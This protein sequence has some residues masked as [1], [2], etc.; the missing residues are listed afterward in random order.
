MM[1]KIN[2]HNGLNENIQSKAD[3]FVSTFISAQLGYSF[4]KA[5]LTTKDCSEDEL[6]PF[7]Y[8]PKNTDFVSLKNLDYK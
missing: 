8:E 2:T 3:T 4:F 7:I 6:Y 5:P 1:Y